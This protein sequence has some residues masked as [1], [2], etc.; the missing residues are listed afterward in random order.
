[1]GT[2]VK[3]REGEGASAACEEVPGEGIL[4]CREQHLAGSWEARGLGHLWISCVTGL[5]MS[6]LW[7]SVSPYLK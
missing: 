6:L 7:V 1:M 3:W 5:R 4:M 2:E